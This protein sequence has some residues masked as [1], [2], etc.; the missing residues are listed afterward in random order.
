MMRSPR[1]EEGN[2]SLIVIAMTF[3]LMIGGVTIADAGSFLGARARAQAAADAAALAAVAQQAPVLGGSED[4]TDA[5]R[6]EAKAN[7]AILVS[8]DCKTGQHYATVEVSIAPRVL[9]LEAW[10]D[11]TVRASATAS[12]D[13]ALFSYRTSG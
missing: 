8:C 1:T 2:V 9:L 10:S 5:A 3:V 6:T 12:I 4:P 11:R 7:G 13:D